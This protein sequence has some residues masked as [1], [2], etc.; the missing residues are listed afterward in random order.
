MYTIEQIEDAIIAVLA[1]LKA[2]LWVR[3]I[4]SY[5]GELEEADLKKMAG[6]FPAIYV[7]YG[8]SGY[9]AH[10]ARKQEKM[11]FELFVC[12]KSLRGE[13]EA[14]RGSG[15]NPGTYRMLRECRSLI[16]GNNLG[17]AELTPFEIKHDTPVWFGGGVSIYAQG[18]ETVQ[19]HLYP[20]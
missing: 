7:V 11:G 10:G 13:E 9:V 19:A 1:P 17:L 4:K 18:Y 12:D 3:E 14:R 15:A 2:S 5:Q 16:T 6:K 8:S 20:S